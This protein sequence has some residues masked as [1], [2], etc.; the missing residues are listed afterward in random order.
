MNY[1]YTRVATAI[2]EVKVADCPYNT[3]RIIELMQKADQANVQIVCFPEL[4][5]TGYTCGDL[6]QQQRLL[7]D[8]ENAL[9][10]ILS[11]SE[12]LQLTTIVG[13]P[14][15]FENRLY[16]TAVVVSRGIL[17]GVIPKSYLPNY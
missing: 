14:V 12:A 6:F 17:C 16:N 1:G 13:M 8:A 7:L 9:S 2:P 3:P 11:A 4:A 10:A 5:I 15:R